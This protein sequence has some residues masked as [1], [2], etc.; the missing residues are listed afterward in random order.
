MTFGVYI[1][2][3]YC[4]KKCPYCDFNSYGVGK[5]IP[6]KEYTEVVLREID[7]YREVIEK[8]PLSS[9]FFGG[10]TPSLFSADSIGKIMNEIIKLAF[11]L[12]SL[13]VSIEINPKT[14]DFK[15]LK[16]FRELGVNRISVGIQ[17]FLERKLKLLGRVNTPGDSR[18]VLEDIIKAGFENFSLDLMFG[19]PFE[20]PDEWRIDLEKA[21]EFKTTHISAYCLTI[22]DDTEFGTL[23]SQG[24]LLL[25]EEETLTEM[26]ILTGDF[27]EAV[28]YKQYEISNFAKPG[29]ECKHNLL[30]WRG[31]NY[32]GFG[33]GAHSH[34]STVE[35]S[36]WGIRWANLKNPDLY[37][38]SV[39]EGEKPVSF[40]E[41]LTKEEALQDKILMGIRLREG[42]NLNSLKERFGTKLNSDKLSALFKEDFI[43][44]SN[45]SL[46]LS[47][48]G[49][50]VSNELAVR[51]IDSLSFQ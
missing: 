12:D 42:I 9:I 21:L 20:T 49:I 15:K 2:I 41:F 51:V 37:M 48:K 44:L 28:G 13:E 26:L 19:V 8:I 4:I 34:L 16:E 27:L 5:L 45:N 38:K 33:A 43:E 29:F 1:H 14:V 23:Y 22:E 6:E 50:L 31:E 10:G 36:L 35:K 7:S 18:A 11:P 3:P 40:K 46:H 17:S 25:P 24:K 30:Y 32:L 39:L 47:K